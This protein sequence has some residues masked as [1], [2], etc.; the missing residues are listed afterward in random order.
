M[1]QFALVTVKKCYGPIAG[2]RAVTSVSGTR[3]PQL[4]SWRFRAS[5][6]TTAFSTSILSSRLENR[7]RRLAVLT[8]RTRSAFRHR[9]ATVDCCHYHRLSCQH[10]MRGLSTYLLRTCLLQDGVF[11][12]PFA[13]FP[14]CRL[15]AH[16]TAEPT[17]SAAP[18]TSENA[19]RQHRACGELLRNNHTR[20]K[21]TVDAVPDLVQ[22]RFCPHCGSGLGWGQGSG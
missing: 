4:T 7:S 14:R 8:T 11:C 5:C 1:P 2:C 6:N 20:M 13:S 19:N 3:E 18:A 9:A 15:R 21:S 12:V 17:S 10:L 22:P 16:F